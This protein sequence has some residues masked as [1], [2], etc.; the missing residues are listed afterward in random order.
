MGW[1]RRRSLQRGR[2]SGLHYTLALGVTAQKQILPG[3]LIRDIGGNSS[4][5][6][7]P[8]SR[9]SYGAQKCWSGDGQGDDKCILRQ[10]KRRK[11]HVEYLGTMYVHSHRQKCYVLEA[12]LRPHHCCTFE[13][14]FPNPTPRFP[15]KPL[16][17]KSS[18]LDLKPRMRPNSFAIV[19]ENPRNWTERQRNKRKQTVP[20]T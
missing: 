13:T 7:R 19:V 20:P 2:E 6:R 1:R 10:R 8:E 4:I 12:A 18:E 17:R 15:K 9:L 5:P 16:T 14:T 11:S 3:M